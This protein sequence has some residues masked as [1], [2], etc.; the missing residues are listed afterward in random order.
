M[1]FVT[2]FMILIYKKNTSKRNYFE[3]V[4][5]K[6]KITQAQMQGLILYFLVL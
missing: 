6:F 3:N 2:I 5:K 1:T 4:K